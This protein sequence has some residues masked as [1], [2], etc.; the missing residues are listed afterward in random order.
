LG[1]QVAV[2]TTADGRLSDDDGDEDL[3]VSVGQAIFGI[4]ARHTT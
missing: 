1:T 3:A 2:F 4:H